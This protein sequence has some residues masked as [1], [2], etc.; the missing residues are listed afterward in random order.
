[1]EYKLLDGIASPADVK[2]LDRGEIEP[3]LGEIREFL[4]DK[5][6]K[7]G[8]HLASNLGV[9]ELS[10]ALHRV[11][12]S[13]SDHIIFDVG[14]QSYVHK[15][16]T[17]RRDRFDEL[18]VP[19]GLSGFT[20]MRESEHD[21]FGAGHSSTSISAA[22]GFAEADRLRGSKNH[23]VCVIGDGAYTGGMVHEAINNC[24]PDLRLVIVL[25]ENGMSISGNKGSFASYL[26]GVRSSR[27]YINAK[28]KTDNFLHKLPLLGKPIKWLLS[29][30]KNCFKRVFFRPNYFEELGFYYI[31][32]IDGND[33]ARVERA[34]E[35]AKGLGKCVIVHLKTTKGKGF[36]EAER[37]PDLYHSVSSA[38]GGGSTYHEVFADEL[39]SLAERD[40]S[41][42]AVTPAMGIGTGLDRFEERYPHRYFDV[43][44]AE[45]HALTFSAGLAAD[46]YKPFCAIYSTFL[47]RGYDNIVH[48]I[49]LQGLPVRMIIDR[50]GLAAADGATH[51]G[52]FDVAF[53]SHIPGV[54]IISPASF[55]SL[56]AHLAYA[57]SAT[58]PVAIR[59]PN[60]GECEMVREHFFRDYDGVRPYLCD[61]DVCDPPRN[62][63]I[64]YG[65][66]AARVLRA[67]RLLAERGVDVGIILVE[68]IKPYAP[69]V[70]FIRSVTGEHSCIVY[71]E[72]GIKNGGAAMIT[73]S[74]LVESGASFASF[75]IAAIDDNFVSPTEIC[76]IYDYAG[77]SAEKLA[78]YFTE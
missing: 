77:L 40:E 4:L 55:V 62:I 21:A 39:N 44:I 26:S 29:T 37:Y 43:G 47:Q 33:Y 16:L 54:E 63:F 38:R 31:G 68:Q 60:A 66:L 19:G 64:T 32:P 34:L 24:R 76:D 15:L 41:I 22:L 10:V 74:K 9:V 17:G 2:R 59:Y 36:A 12:D 13:P 51:H 18:R 45:E 30:G 57:A 11:F 50:A 14:H 73:E 27:R 53:L 28:R 25:N 56:R 78:A 8:G 35:T 42:L 65:Q 5:V 70:D 46:G 7:S 69:A 48:D 6:T 71:A 61:F 20:L 72:E 67:E 75:R 49:A 1:M 58:A 3:L 23:T 52:I